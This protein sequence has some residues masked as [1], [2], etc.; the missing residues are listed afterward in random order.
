MGLG[1][2]TVGTISP[3]RRRIEL[4]DVAAL[5]DVD[6]ALASFYVEQV[7]AASELTGVT[8]REIREWF[9]DEL[10]TP[11]GFRT[12]VLTG[13]GARGRA[14]VHE[15]ENRHLIRAESKRG[16]LWYEISHDR[17]VDPIQTS[18]AAW[19]AEH[20]HPLQIDARA[21]ERQD[22]APG[23]LIGGEALA[24]AELWAAANPDDLTEIDR[25]YLEAC[26][27]A[28]QQLVAIQR[29]AVRNRR[30]AIASSSLSILVVLAL[31]ATAVFLV[32]S[33]SN[34]REAERQ[35]TD[36][37]ASKKDAEDAKQDALRQKATAVEQ[38][39][40]AEE[41]KA[42]AVKLKG[43]AEQKA[44][45]A[46]A[47]ADEARQATAKAESEAARATRA[48]S[49]ANTAKRTA[50]ENEQKATA[51][52]AEAQKQTTLAK[53][54]ADTAV[55]NADRALAASLAV[56]LQPL[57]EVNPGLAAA[58]AA[59]ALKLSG[60]SSEEVTAAMLRAREAVASRGAQPYGYALSAGDGNVVAVSLSADGR[61]VA[62]VNEFG[63]VQVWDTARGTAVGSPRPVPDS[64][65]P[66]RLALSPDGQRVVVSTSGRTLVWAVDGSTEPERT[67]PS[68]A[69]PWTLR[70]SG[71]GRFVALDWNKNSEPVPLGLDLFDLV[72]GTHVVMQDRVDPTLSSDGRT[73]LVRAFS[74]LEL[75]NLTT[76]PPTLVTTLSSAT[77]RPVFSPDGNRIAAIVEP[78]RP[79][80]P[81]GP[82]APGLIV[83]D[84]RS[85][86]EVLP[87]PPLTDFVSVV[88]DPSGTLLGL[89][90]ADSSTALVEVNTGKE[91]QRLGP[92]TDRIVFTNDPSI[93]L[94]YTADGF[95]FAMIP[96]RY[97]RLKAPPFAG[98]VP[99]AEGLGGPIGTP[100]GA[101]VM[102]MAMNGAWLA[103]PLGNAVQIVRPPPGV[104]SARR[105]ITRVSSADSDQGTGAVGQAFSPDGTLLAT[106][107]NRGDLIVTNVRTRQTVADV[108]TGTAAVTAL[109]FAHVDGTTV[110][111]AGGNDGAVTTLDP[112]TLAMRRTQVG[113][114]AI[115]SIGVRPDG[116][117][118]AV[119]DD[120]GWIVQISTSTGALLGTRFGHPLDL[121]N[122][123]VELVYSPNGSNLGSFSGPAGWVWDVR[124]PG[125]SPSRPSGGLS[126]ETIGSLRFS[127][128]GR[129]FIGATSVV[130][131]VRETPAVNFDRVFDVTPAGRV[132]AA[133]NGVTRVWNPDGTPY[134]PALVDPS[135]WLPP[136]SIGAPPVATL[137]P[138]GQLLS[139][140]LA[141]VPFFR[142]AQMV[143]WNVD[144]GHQLGTL[145]APGFIPDSI[146]FDPDGTTLYTI[147][148]PVALV[149]D[150]LSI[151]AACAIAAPD[152]HASQL[153]PF[154]DGR[155][156]TACAGVLPA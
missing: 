128:D 129:Y 139:V 112:T 131:L 73:M 140:I 56:R 84:A 151:D 6:D 119:G 7:T 18:N 74:G 103:Y 24:A 5:G 76:S 1:S 41:A 154:L 38:A 2:T 21:W 52:A 31:V 68:D 55:R 26:R 49:D 53:Q 114:A 124:Q 71:D 96:A 22:R 145:A 36:A 3:A 88:Y 14:V 91:L 100:E 136:Q 149:W 152:V 34:A 45:E 33:Q 4:E 132:V 135:H 61:R 28:E 122:A 19:R 11:Q 40:Q 144:T 20:L 69:H 105:V 115:R 29:A 32:R 44:I 95:P 67:F 90:R 134:G 46:T 107:T 97:W 93:V 35:R 23:L 146:A 17:L 123:V 51:S 65:G 64:T 82:T 141:P 133:K 130:D 110:V 147:A 156:P 85:G 42:E 59:E 9:E 47:S 125:R 99:F 148:G 92:G 120:D 58:L 87:R 37:L 80:D 127:A 62:S 102:S 116:R 50:E 16:A 153:L 27:A 72:S 121:P 30:L 109:G 79:G 8:V 113:S 66:Y 10:I 81:P 70:I 39:K 78:G 143:V 137:D 106:G 126:S 111:V 43:I 54:N 63:T 150:V 155:Q 104:S 48:E 101:G 117:M 57:L 94:A 75:W 15:L 25:A 83:V 77:Q 60:A 108:S 138:T 86:T 98:A 118:M 12:Q 89:A 142:D 13:P